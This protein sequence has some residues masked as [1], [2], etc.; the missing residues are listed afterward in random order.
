MILSDT[1]VKRPVL[2]TVMSLLLIIFGVICYLRLPLRE[3]PD[4]DSPV[5]TVQT[6]YTGASASVVETKITKIIEDGVSGISGLKTVESSSEDGMSVVTLE[7]TAATD[8]ENAANDVRDKVGRI[9]SRLP[10][11][12]KSPRVFKQDVARSAV[13]ILPLLHPDMTQMELTDYA[14]RNIVDELSTV[15]GVSE[16]MIY[17]EKR[18]SMRI[19]L[20]RKAMAAH[21]V[22]VA[23]I[24]KIMNAEN[25]E[26]PA[27]RI[28]SKQREFVMRLERLY[29]SPQEFS[30]M[31]LFEGDDGHL[32]RLGDV[33]KIEIGPE[34]MRDN[35]MVDGHNA[36]SIAISKQSKANTLDVI[37][38]VKAK[39]P[40]LI[41][42]MPPG[43]KM[44]IGRDDSVFIQAAVHEV[45]ES[46]I[47]ASILVIII[48]YLFLG[49]L[50]A[51]A[52]PAVTVPISLIA[53][54]IVLYAMGYSVNLLTLLAMVLATGLVVDDSIVV[55]ENI[56][57]RV[58]EGEHPLTAAFNGAREVGF[59]VVATTLVL[60]AVFLPICL[61]DGNTG[62]LFSEFAM[63]MVA[64]VVFSSFVAL[65][66]SPVMCSWL[67]KPR[68]A[69]GRFAKIDELIMGNIEKYYD[70]FLR[71][72][73]Q[74][75]YICLFLG[76]LM[77]GLGAGLFK[78][79]PSEFEPE[80]D[81]AMLMM[82]M[83][84]PEGTGFKQTEEYTAEVSEAP[85]KLYEKGIARHVLIRVPG[86]RNVQGAVNN[87]RIIM[88]LEYWDKR[89]ETAKQLT[90][91]LYKES[92]KIPGVKTIVYQPSGLNP[93]S[94]QPVQFVIGG[95]TYETLVEW[96]DKLLEKAR[97]YP[98]LIGVDSDYQETMPQNRIVIDR[99]RAG[100]LGVSAR[101][102]GSALESMLGSKQVTTYTDNGE[103]YEVI[104]QGRDEDR[105]SPLDIENIYV[106]SART[107]TLHPLSNLVKISEIADSG[108]LKRY[109]RIRSITISGSVAPGYTL[110]E[111][112]D[113]LEKTVRDEL[114]RDV[115]I[116]YKG[117]SKDFKESSSSMVFVFVL[118]MIV[119]FLVLAAQFESYSSPFVIMLT[120]P[121]GLVGALAGLALFGATLNIYSQIGLVMLIG[122]AAKNGILIAEFAN[123][124]RDRGVE[125]AEAVYQAARLRL[126]PIAMTGLSTAIGALPLV[127]ASGAGKES[128]ISLG[129]VIFF[130][131]V[132]ACFL[133]AV[134]VPVGYMYLSRRSGTPGR[135]AKKLA[136]LSGKNLEH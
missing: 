115:K 111:C 37:N 89:K 24:E 12:A 19:W 78:M 3:Y 38:G 57:R 79:I 22:T 114:P 130:G 69:A 56:Y 44:E 54:F 46:L 132:V 31:V 70:K 23:D 120:V 29:R 17:G 103:E 112:L 45:Y 33:A 64:A 136:E 76:I 34:S 4:I 27:G 13:L 126:R 16:V 68:N 73:T 94:G 63:A 105:R 127:F 30:S 75:P 95:P 101:D 9:V 77:L 21:G 84:A 32:V 118:A 86:S 62:K 74:H 65:T 80:E 91:Y 67:L 97:K 1:S 40:E 2:A 10:D 47:M 125:F 53:A 107:N 102:I 133:T 25:V 85:L 26:L 6:E 11:E 42:N 106:R 58:E 18:Y 71:K 110:G 93:F 98:G 49:S 43:M 52:V 48:I 135:V 83:K 41:R 66:L 81:R 61:L 124:H 104:L 123:Q 109:N 14:D 87:S 8:I 36:I 100:K 88:P 134:V 131:S 122:L 113:F 99:D 55:L 129:L 117:M 20:D 59:A 119:V 92:E 39:L 28:E 51:A 35:F 121:L 15:D 50:R 72:V 5:V 128:R 60:V 82:N 90:A 7:F 96:R 108:V 116:N